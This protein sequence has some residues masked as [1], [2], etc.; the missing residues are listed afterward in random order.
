MAAS[1]PGRGF[2]IDP[3]GAVA[4][5][6]FHESINLAA[7][8]KLP[9]L[10]VCENN[11][12]AMGTHLDFSHSTLD[13]SKKAASYGVA[14]SWVDGMDV[15]AVEASAAKVCEYI[16]AGNGPYF[17]ECRTYRFRAHSMYDPELYREKAEVEEWKKRDP[18]PALI[19]RIA[20]EMPAE[21][22]VA[23]LER[24]VAKEVD[25]AIA[26][27]EAG[28]LEPVEHLTRF[29]YSDRSRV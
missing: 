28:T 24:Q 22:E 21:E 20:Q 11:R 15:L 18:I 25:Q 7:L 13:L 26:F 12:Y 2:P 5:G 16:R 14:A 6:E 27:A 19:R 1:T 29:V 8:W 9:V 4:E 10:F 17:L 3:D 23:E